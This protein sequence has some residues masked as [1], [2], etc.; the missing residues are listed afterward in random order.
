MRPLVIALV[1]SSFTQTVSAAPTSSGLPT[2]KGYCSTL[3]WQTTERNIG[4][5]MRSAAKRG[6]CIM[7]GPAR[8]P[9][10]ASH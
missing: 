8:V 1:A 10:G 7:R 6:L 4:N 9:P 5:C 3:G 2:C